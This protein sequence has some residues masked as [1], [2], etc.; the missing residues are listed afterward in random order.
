MVGDKRSFPLSWELLPELGSSNLSE[1]QQA[2][3]LMMPLWQNYQICALGDS[4]LAPGG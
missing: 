3:F 1:Q 4:Y 2:L